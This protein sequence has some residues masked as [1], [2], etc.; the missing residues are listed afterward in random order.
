M[1]RTLW[2]QT[3]QDDLAAN[4]ALGPDLAAR[5]G[6]AAIAAGCFLAEHLAAGAEVAATHRRWR[7][8]KTPYPLFYR[9][10]PEEV[11]VLR[12][13]HDRQNWSTLA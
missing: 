2:T 9:I 10:V 5:V 12:V 11:Q 7:V 13:R 1:S 8:A 6:R 4:A 3:A